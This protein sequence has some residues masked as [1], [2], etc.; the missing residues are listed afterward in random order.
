MSDITLSN[1][2]R[3]NLLSLQ[4]NS[5]LLE[6][7]QNRLATGKKVNTALDDPLNYFQSSM[8]KVRGNDLTRL[9]DGIGLGIKT[10]EQADNGI[11]A[12]TTLTETIQ[13]GARTAKLSSA[14]NPILGSASDKDYR[15]DPVTGTFP[16]MATTATSMTITPT[17]PAGY[18]VAAGYPAPA[19][20]TVAIPVPAGPLRVP[21]DTTGMTAQSLANSINLAAGNLGPN[22]SGVVRPYINA[23]VDEGGR[24][25]ITNTS[26][27]S[28]IAG[29]V[30]NASMRIQVAGGAA[31][32]NTIGSIFGNIPAPTTA[33]T[34]TDTGV[35]N[36]TLN[37]SR[38][39]FAQQ[40]SDIIDQITNLAKDSSFNGTNL[41]YGQTL[42]M[43]FN[44]DNTT[45]LVV[46]GVVFDATG[47]GI[48]RN[49]NAYNFQ[50]DKEIDD[51]V[52][53]TV[54]A[55]KTLRTQ[56][57]VFGQNMTVAKT[58]EEFTKEAVKFLNVGAD[59]LVVA[60]INEEGANI[61][62]LQTRQQLSTQ[63]LSLAAQSEQSVL[64]LFN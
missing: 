7:T 17:I 33:S 16:Q 55:L 14:T 36:G 38:L 29:V 45:R 41:L 39:R 9:L 64:R 8:M 56:A 51:A 18:T 54:D 4:S 60:D 37:E 63:A 46:R 6:R 3:S 2:I 30:S 19:A 49:D 26:G 43:V 15:P 35:M 47:L 20:F 32:D 42:D 57:A 22:I 44:E 50:S 59:N 28:S 13:A 5:D 11:R 24:L 61:L 53:V 10:I 1:G 62:A 12:M 25:I 58:R 34:A 27:S 23:E 31:P 21:G 48:T 40:Y 52:Q